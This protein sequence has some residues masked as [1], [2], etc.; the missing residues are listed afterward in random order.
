MSTTLKTAQ[1][2]LASKNKRGIRDIPQTVRE[3]VRMTKTQLRFCMIVC[4]VLVIALIVISLIAGNQAVNTVKVNEAVA[5]LEDAAGAE[6]IEAPDVVNNPARIQFAEG[7]TWSGEGTRVIMT[8][9]SSMSRNYWLTLSSDADIATLEGIIGEGRFLKVEEVDGNNSLWIVMAKDEE[10]QNQFN[11]LE[12]RVTTAEGKIEQNIQDIAEIN[13]HIAQTDETIAELIQK[14]TE[15]ES[16]IEELRQEDTRLQEEIDVLNET[17]ENID[18]SV[19]IQ[20]GSEFDKE[21]GVLTLKSKGGT[22]D[23]QI[24]F[25]LNFGIF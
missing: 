6:R 12:E 20:E 23:I 7:V 18:S 25:D 17:V 22:N 3:G 10:M 14:D 15:L 1:E 13:E 4:A 16:S 8:E 21:N 5:L 2:I 24:Q 11:D 9:R 19:H